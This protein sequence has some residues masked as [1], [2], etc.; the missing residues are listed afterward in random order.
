MGFT[1]ARFTVEI[2]IEAGPAEPSIPQPRDEGTVA[3]SEAGTNIVHPEAPPRE[4]SIDDSSRYVPSVRSP[5]LWCCA[6]NLHPEKLERSK[7]T[8]GTPSNTRSGPGHCIFLCLGGPGLS[9]T[10]VV[11]KCKRPNAPRG[12]QSQTLIFNHEKSCKSGVVT[13]YPKTPDEQAIECDSDIF[14]RLQHAAISKHGSWKAWVP[15]YGVTSVEEVT[16][17][18]FW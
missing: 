13:Y 17:G 11:V 15:F 5:K 12:V 2:D 4:S 1:N 7:L 10:V 8:P 18:I 6:S 3:V 16:V 9:K 14:Q